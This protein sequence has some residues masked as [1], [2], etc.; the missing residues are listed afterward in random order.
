M[1]RETEAAE[2]PR[3][4]QQHEAMN[5]IFPERLS[6]WIGSQRPEMDTVG[7]SASSVYLFENMV[8]KVSRSGSESQGEAAMLRWLHGKLPV[9]KMFEFFSQEGTDYLLMERLPGKMSC[10]Q[11]Y[12]KDPGALVQKLA[13]SLKLWWSLDPLDCPVDQCLDAKLRT[14][15][16]NIETGIATEENTE[17]DTYGPNGFQS[18]GHLLTW[19]NNNRPEEDLCVTH[20]D[21]CLQ[22]LFFDGDSLSGFLDLSRSGVSDRWQDI[23][24]CWRSIR[25]NLSGRYARDPSA[26]HYEDLLFDYLDIPKDPVKLRYYLLL[27]ELF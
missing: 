25:D 27:D 5:H 14:A 24:L 13:G 20:G 26:Q 23:A 12:L 6:K 17:P 18:P 7:L 2:A 9:P 3:F 1:D 4:C 8:L 19:L 16:H 22:N 10:S 15:K 21:F 11:D